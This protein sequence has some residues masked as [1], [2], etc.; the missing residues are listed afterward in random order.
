[1]GLHERVVGELGVVRRAP[2]HARETPKRAAIASSFRRA[3]RERAVDD[4]GAQHRQ[5][6]VRRGSNHAG[7]QMAAPRRHDRGGADQVC[8]TRR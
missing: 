1:M 3:R 8:L 7:E 2:D 4:L 6:R 5:D